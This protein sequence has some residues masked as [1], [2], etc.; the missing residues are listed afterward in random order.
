[1]VYTDMYMFL[2]IHTGSYMAGCSVGLFWGQYESSE[3][4]VHPSITEPSEGLV[5]GPE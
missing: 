5:Q 1:M 4:R 3:S 2:Y